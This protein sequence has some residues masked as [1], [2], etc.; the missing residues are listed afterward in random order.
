M[1]I[2][3]LGTGTSQGVPVIGCQCAVCTSDD[4]HDN[5]LRSSVMI[6]KD[7]RVAVIDSGPDFRQQMLRE[8]VKRLDA[9]IFTHEHKD[10][11]AG[12]DD[13]RAFN[14]VMKQKVDVYAT[15]RVQLAIRREFPYI[16]DE[17]KYPGIPEL[18]MHTISNSA[19]TAAGI[20]FI[21]V[22]V[23]HYML[24]VFGFRTGDFTY[25]TDAKS[26]TEQEKKKILGCHTIVINALRH[27]THVSHFTLNEAVELLL[28][29]KCKQGWLTH[30]SHQLGKHID[31][32]SSL[33]SHIR[34]AYD[35]LKLEF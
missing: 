19:F 34:C 7:G 28:E 17:I 3:F 30:I 29:L 35:G 2:T 27:E 1:K 24:P 4:N 11:I 26:I 13:I 21:P 33:P 25:I 9:L 8:G 20:D 31:V 12:L 23:V 14:Y 5:R 6:E 10:H 16:F 18:N 22:E 15:D 32:D